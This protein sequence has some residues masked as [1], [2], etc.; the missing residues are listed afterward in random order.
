MAITNTKVRKVYSTFK[1]SCYV[2]VVGDTT[3]EV[4]DDDEIEIIPPTKDPVT[5]TNTG[6]TA[7]PPNSETISTSTA[8]DTPQSFSFNSHYPTH[9]RKP[10]DRYF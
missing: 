3:S 6:V 4:N 8:S 10:P 2:E 5:L 1:R 7:L 9:N